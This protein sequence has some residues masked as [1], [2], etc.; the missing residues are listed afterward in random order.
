M[1]SIHNTFASY[2]LFS[3]PKFS[4]VCQIPESIDG[5]IKELAFSPSYD[6]APPPY[7]P[8]PSTSCLSFSSFVSPVELTDG[9]E[10]GGAKSYVGEKAWSSINQLKLSGQIPIGLFYHAAILFKTF[11]IAYGH[12]ER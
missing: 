5:F 8:L 1:S 9:K 6:L 2:P 11:T 10:G 4:T 3:K 7:L 12:R